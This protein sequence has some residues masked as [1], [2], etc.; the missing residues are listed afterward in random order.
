[1]TGI[2]YD[3][4][5]FLSETQTSS[6]NKLYPEFDKIKAIKGWEWKDVDPLSLFT[7]EQNR[8]RRRELFLFEYDPKNIRSEPPTNEQLAFK[9]IITQLIEGSQIL[10][11]N[12]NIKISSPYSRNYEKGLPIKNLLEKLADLGVQW[13][14][15]GGQ[16]LYIYNGNILLGKFKSGFVSLSNINI[17]KP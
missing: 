15:T 11:D 14:Q 1:M 2:I 16:N 5:T 9:I 17:D 10:L 7:P 4:R 3:G 13:G 12:S 8:A 6:F